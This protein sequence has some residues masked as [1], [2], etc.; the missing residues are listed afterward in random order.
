MNMWVAMKHKTHNIINI[1]LTTH[2]IGTVFEDN[3]QIHFMASICSYKNKMVSNNSRQGF[4]PAST[5]S[6]TICHNEV[7]SYSTSKHNAHILLTIFL[8]I[9]N[10]VCYCVTSSGIW[11]PVL[12]YNQLP[13]AKEDLCVHVYT[14]KGIL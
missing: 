12:F 13:S 1:T 10:N 4:C 3:N 8:L 5:T 9:F 2:F 7:F 14:E 11:L 6:I